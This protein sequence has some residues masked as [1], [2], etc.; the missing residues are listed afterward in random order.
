MHKYRANGGVKRR[1]SCCDVLLG[2]EVPYFGDAKYHT[3]GGV[4]CCTYESVKYRVGPV[5]VTRVTQNAA[6]MSQHVLCWEWNKRSE[7]NHVGFALFTSPVTK[8]VVPQ[9]R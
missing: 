3:Y 6:K 8:R 4:K 2:R 9:F 7:S 5:Q 1:V